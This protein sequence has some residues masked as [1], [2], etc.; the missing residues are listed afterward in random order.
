MRRRRITFS[1]TL[2][3]MAIDSSR[4]TIVALPAILQMGLVVMTRPHLRT[5]LRKLGSP[6]E[7]FRSTPNSCNQRLNFQ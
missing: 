4:K 7:T 1:L 2:T 5:K 3:T 6:S